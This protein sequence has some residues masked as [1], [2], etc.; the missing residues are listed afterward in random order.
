[1]EFRE[2]Q[3]RAVM[4]AISSRK[5]DVRDRMEWRGRALVGLDREGADLVEEYAKSFQMPG[6]MGGPDHWD[7]V[8]GALAKLS[9]T[10]RSQYLA[11]LDE[12][13][14]S[15]LE[16]VVAVEMLNAQDLLSGSVRGFTSWE[17][18]AATITADH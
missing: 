11:G 7:L 5:P 4:V 10:D 2:F 15:A 13:T 6:G 1:M 12:H 17:A 8:G 14:R 16:R 3:R 9:E 18:A